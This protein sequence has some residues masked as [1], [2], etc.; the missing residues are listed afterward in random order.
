MRVVS[1]AA[2]LLT[3][4]LTS[5]CL[6]DL[7]HMGGRH[8][9]AGHAH[10]KHRGG[11]GHGPPA[12]A[13][14]HGYR[15]HQGVNRVELSFDSGLGVYLVVDR[16][17][18]YFLDGHYLRLEGGHWLISTHLD[19]PWHTHAVQELPPGLRAKHGK[20]HPAKQGGHRKHPGKRG[21]SKGK[22]EYR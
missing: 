14:A 6:A 2:V 4:L 22:D 10:G 16:P 8:H 20:S 18:Y 17:H 3:A 11:R 9:G 19:G 15:H 7:G 12:H 13:P 5:G 21:K 1:L